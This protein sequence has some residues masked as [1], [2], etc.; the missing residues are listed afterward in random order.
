MCTAGLTGDLRYVESGFW[1]FDALFVPQQHPARDLQDTFFI[2]D[3]KMA[4]RPQ[5]DGPEDKGD[6]A[7]YWENVKAVHQVSVLRVHHTV[8]I[9]HLLGL[10][11]GRMVDAYAAS[12]L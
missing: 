11:V 8:G 9:C 2:S 6:Y 1:N 5:P 3:P 7:A 4:H 12:D 10:D